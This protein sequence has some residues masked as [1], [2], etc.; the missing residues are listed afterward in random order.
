MANREIG[1]PGIA[2][3][4]GCA[5]FLCSWH[6]KSFNSTLFKTSKN[7]YGATLIFNRYNGEGFV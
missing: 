2:E 3:L 5:V 7:P 6:L 1:V 4:F